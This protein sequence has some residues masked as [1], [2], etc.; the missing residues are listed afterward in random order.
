MNPDA[1]IDPAVGIPI[2]VAAW[3]LLG[4][5]KWIEARRER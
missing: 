2:A 4:V 1:H 3:A 5:I